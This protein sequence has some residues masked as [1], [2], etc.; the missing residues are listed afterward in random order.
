MQIN[1]LFLAACK[2]QPKPHRTGVVD[3]IVEVLFETVLVRDDRVRFVAARAAGI[4]D[5]AIG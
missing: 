5:V 4:T 1:P 3:H 2:H